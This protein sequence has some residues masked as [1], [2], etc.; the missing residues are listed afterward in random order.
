MNSTALTFHIDVSCVLSSTSRSG[1]VST[2]CCQ[3]SASCPAGHQGE[4][5]SSPLGIGQ[6]QD[7]QEGSSVLLRAQAA[8]K[9]FGWSPP[10]GAET[11]TSHQASV[12][13]EEPKHTKTK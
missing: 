10:T 6:R 12:G 1:Q 11:P 3:E 5:N 4:Q 13:P 9:S 8:R 2:D 7:T